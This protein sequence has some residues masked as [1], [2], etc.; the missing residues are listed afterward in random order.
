MERRRTSG[1][2]VS[3]FV[4]LLMC[5]GHVSAVMAQSPAITSGTQWLQAQLQTDGSVANAQGIATDF[6]ADSETLDTLLTLQATTPTQAALTQGLINADPDTGTENLSRKM[7]ATAVLGQD[8]SSLVTTLLATQNAD[9][10]F[11]DDVGYQST[12]F[13]TAYAVQALNAAGQGNSNAAYQAASFLLNQQQADG[14][15]A[16]LQGIDIAY[17]TAV[18]MQALAPY[19]TQFTA[20]GSALTAGIAYLQSAQQPGSDWGLPYINASVVTAL[21]DDAAASSLVKA[22]ATDLAGA[23]LAD[24]SWADDPFT[25][26]LALRALAAAEGTAVPTQAIGAVEG[27]VVEAGTGQPI[28]GATVFVASD[29]S[30][31]TTTNADGYYTFSNLPAGQVSLVANAAGYSAATTV[32]SVAMNTMTQA[33]KLVLAQNSD[34]GMVFGKITSQQD[35]TTIAGAM[36]QIAGPGQYQ[37]TTDA[38][39]AFVLP[40]V[41]SGNYTL[42]VTANGFITA[43]GGIGIEAGSQY[44]VNQSLLLN[45][46]YQGSTPVTVSATVVDG[47]SGNAIPGAALSLNGSMSGSTASDGSVS[48][49]NVPLGSY[50]ATVSA[51]GYATGNYTFVLLAGTNGAL[52]TLTLYPQTDDS[53]A[54]TLTVIGTVVSGLGNQPLAGATVTRM[55][56]GQVLTSGADGSFTLSGLT[57]LSVSL[58][59]ADPGYTTELFTLTASGYGTVVQTLALPPSSSSSSSSATSV[60]LSG[61]VT[62]SVSGAA[63]PNATIALSDGSATVTTDSNGSYQLSGIANLSFKL[64]VSATGHV[65]QTVPVTL[66]Q[67][68]NYTLDVPLTIAPASTLQV[69]SVD[70]KS[71]TLT[72]T[73]TGVFT[74][75]VANSGSTDVE[76]ALFAEITNAKGAIVADVGGQIPGTTTKPSSFDVPAAGNVSAEF[77]WTSKQLAAGG[78]TVTVYAAVSATA[79]RLNP[80][81]TV[82]AQ[83]NTVVTV[84]PTLAITGQL[85]FNPPLSQAGSQT[86]VA[87][88]ALVINSGNQTLETVPLHLTVTDPATGNVLYSADAQV[89]QLPVNNNVTVSFGSWL[90]TTIGN[91]KAQVVSADNTIAGAIE[92]TLYV[93]NKATAQMT[94]DRTIVAPGSNVVHAKVAIQGVD[95][96]QAISTDPLFFAV[97]RAT[98]NAGAYVAPNAEQWVNNHHCVSCHIESESLY[99]L[100][101][102]SGKA[103]IDQRAINFLATAI[104]TTHNANG[105]LEDYFQGAGADIQQTTMNLWGLNKYDDKGA[106]FSMKLSAAMFLHTQRQVSGSGF[107]WPLDSHP[108]FAWWEYQDGIT[109]LVIKDM[110]DVVRAAPSVDPSQV[111]S[112]TWKSLTPAGFTNGATPNDVK[113]GPDGRLYTL[114]LSG[115]LY[116]VDPTTG[117]T[118]FTQITGLPNTS[119][120][121]AIGPDGTFYISGNGF[122]ARVA[123]GQTAATVISRPSGIVYVALSP[124][125]VLYGCDY[126]TSQLLRFNSDGTYAVLLTSTT[127]N[128][129]GTLAF[130]AAGN[131]MIADTYNYDLIEYA[132]DGTVSTFASGMQNTPLRITSDGQ[133]GWYV[134]TFYEEPLG[135]YDAPQ[136]YHFNADGVGQAL[137]NATGTY[138]AGITVLNGEPVTIDMTQNLMETLAPQ[139]MPVS[140]DLALL[141]QDIAG[142]AQYLLGV[143]QDGNTSIP[144]QA[145]RLWGMAEARSVITESGLQSQLSQAIAYL[146]A[147]LRSEQHTDGGWGQTETAPSDAMVTA[148]VG[149]ALNYSHPSSS[150]AVTRNAIQF[151]LNAQQGDGSWYSAD[152]IMYTRLAATG[153]VM[154]YLPDALQFLGGIDVDLNLK[155]VPGKASLGNFAPTPGAI[156]VN[157]DGSSTYNWHLTG[158]TSEEDVTF[159]VNLPNMLA[160]ETRPVAS[161]ATLQF[162]NSFTNEVLTTNLDIPQVKAVSGLGITVGTDRSQYPANTDVAITGVVGNNGVPTTNAQVTLQISAADG[163]VVA[164]LPA[165]TGLQIATGAQQTYTAQ[166]NTAQYLPGTYKVTAQIVDDYGTVANAAVAAFSIASSSNGNVGGAQATLRTTTDRTTYNTTDTVY[167]AD[168]VQSVTDNAL[169]LLTHLHVVVTDPAGQTIQTYDH[170]LGQLAPGATLNLPDKLALNHVAQGQ[171]SV[172]AQLTDSTGTTLAT[173]QTTF[174]VAEDLT[175]TLI[176][177]VTVQSPQVYQG[178]PDVCTDTVINT[179]TLDATSQPIRQLLVN[180]ADG[181]AVSTTDSTVTL[182][183]GQQQQKVRTIGTDSLAVGDYACVLQAEIS[184]S[185]DSLGY[186]HFHVA[187]PPIKIGANMAVGQHGRVLI[188]TD[189]PAA[190][191]GNQDPFG[192]T[193]VPGLTQQNQHLLQMLHQAGWSVT[194]VTNATDFQTQFETQGYEVYVILS[195]AVKLPTALQ[196]EL[197]QAVNNGEGLIVAG[198]HDDRNSK[199]DTALGVHTTGKS[200][201]ATG[202]SLDSGSLDATGGQ[203]SF[204]VDAEPASVN[205]VSAT[206]VGEFLLSNGNTAPAVF[207]YTYGSGK[208]IYMPFDLALEEAAAGNNSLF[209]QLMLDSLAYVHPATLTP[210]TGSVLPIVLTLDNEGI[211]TP[212]RAL[213]TLPPGVTVIDPNGATVNGNTLTWTFDLTSKGE[214]LPLTFWA[215]VPDTAGSIDFTTKVQ[216]GTDPNFVDKANTDLL[217]GVQPRP[218]PQPSSTHQDAVITNT[219][220]GS[221]N[222]RQQKK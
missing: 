177:T 147:K 118:G 131:L 142:G 219:S 132:A 53:A 98:T 212:G 2:G 62:D 107:M 195:E 207:T 25:T 190:Y 12:A 103:T 96:T 120:G 100:S 135:S 197:V 116:W 122:V 134:A 200:L 222:G 59:V 156:T 137:L 216:S 144:S 1:L 13:D 87:I 7:M 189:D 152:G 175:K 204:P 181:T 9:G 106:L 130:D 57:G 27:Y 30:I 104:A 47:V 121:L 23:Q 61:T 78:Y 158:V 123:P 76:A 85:V 124:N 164:T 72:G 15:W 215:R 108:N 208:T 173:G 63:I 193:N 70:A 178:D 171:F 5:L 114:T 153:L 198:N 119:Y 93:G 99:G 113:L 112:Y 86:P 206:P 19:R 11:G 139:P 92:G 192:P 84:N 140:T 66:S 185:W 133:G 186:A 31:T 187:P 43:S 149:L 172:S 180:L 165:V 32:A 196:D 94:V 45:G 69:L 161:S 28:V 65:T 151:L 115:A 160:N 203:V 167:I 36:V 21:A 217:I 49:G 82:L 183:A 109:G 162:K 68:G 143:Y 159:D 81:G 60:Q 50:Q 154:D 55:D 168:L 73:D 67:F 3:I 14:S 56:T 218:S 146:D 75:T 138:T 22:A 10:G 136:M 46:S 34:T 188:L 58:Q 182:A 6:Q 90:P 40:S 127:L 128:H 148:I 80:H 117:A 35:G 110:A 4:V 74:A 221:A 111:M 150:D 176:G 211:P 97:Q 170:D 209:D 89:T 141:Q 169:L 16:D 33:A 39:G 166:W 202:L 88:S 213:V 184:G 125:G 44:Q 163:T 205:K 17:N 174:N 91:L 179:G 54:T 71:T 210:Y 214:I 220:A 29:S 41:M 157:S 95:I 52:G 83:G 64:V 101:G 145:L 199:L 24:G 201:S 194:L 79:S 51:P 8:A 191:P 126:S 129:P 155:D 37:V 38:K 105:T 42:T 26:A 48:I 102:A 20:A 77:D 18:V